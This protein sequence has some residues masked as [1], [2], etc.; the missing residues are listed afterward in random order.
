MVALAAS[1]LLF[2][3]PKPTAAQSVA[4]TITEVQPRLVKVYGVGG[5]RGLEA[6]QSGFLI[7]TEGHVLTV[8]SYVLDTDDITVTLADGRKFDAE[9]VGADPRLEVAVLKIE[10]E[11]LPAFDLNRAVDVPAGARVLAFSNLF[12]VATGNEPVSVQHGVISVK[13]R[14]EARRG[15]FQTAYDGPVYVVDAVTNNP[16]AAGGALV[17]R[18]GE[19]IAMLGKELRNARNNTWLNYGLPV[20]ALRDSVQAIIAGNFE[21]ASD[22][23]PDTKP[24]RS[25][26][27]AELGILMVPNVV[28]RTPPYVD[29]VRPG[30]AAESAG[31]QPD[32]L[33][34]FAN[35]RF[36]QTCKRLE[37]EL[38]YVDYE[39]PVTLT[40]LRGGEMLEFTLQ[41]DSKST[42]VP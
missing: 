8:W 38:E 41:A 26:T 19:L 1:I 4:D 25:L 36:I 17:T 34:V 20:D 11:A 29:D 32:D 28:E 10:G 23:P 37:E 3:P 18:Q 42:Q 13:T 9:L 7:S 12:G 5:L 15:V 16:G 6:Y 30:S 24:A 40:A 35:D 22:Q 27:L 2:L 39:D 33:I 14:L 21:P 31:I